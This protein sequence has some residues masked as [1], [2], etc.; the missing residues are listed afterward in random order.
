[1]KRILL[2]LAAITVIPAVALAAPSS[3]E[4]ALIGDMPYDARHREEY[5]EVM[6]AIDSANLA[7][8]VHDGDFW[9]DGD[10]WTEKLGGF[11]PCSDEAFEDRLNLAQSSKHPFIFVVGDNEWADCYRAKPRTFEPLERLAKIRKMFFSSDRSLGRASLRLER[12]S[13]DPRYSEFRENARWKYGDALF[14]T[15]H[16]LGSNDNLGRTQEMDAEHAKRME[17]NLAWM[18]ESFALARRDGAR[19]VM[20]IAQADPRF[21]NT[22]PADMQRRYM[23]E[24]LGFKAPEVRR[25]TAFDGFLDALEQETLAFG[26][27]VVYVHGD[28]HLFRIDKPLVGTQSRRIIENFTRVETFGYPYAHW[29]RARVD[30]KDPNV[31]SFR[32][33]IVKANLIDHSRP[34]S[35]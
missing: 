25:S 32:E 23:L 17:A 10:K 30:T 3:F 22:W 31:F 2:A 7:F 18:K 15:L 6:N 34:I 8:V 11:P 33:G 27:P 35:P 9:Y 1:M 4:F 5:V 19:A 28:S 13:D 14:V 16:L 12:Q 20:I 24:G 29:V 26:K 21:E